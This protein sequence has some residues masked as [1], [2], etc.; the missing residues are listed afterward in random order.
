M[1]PCPPGFRARP[2]PSPSR[3]PGLMSEV[4]LPL[5]AVRQHRPSG[6]PAH[7]TQ[8][9]RSATA[10]EETVLAVGLEARH[11]DARRQL[12]CLEHLAAL[13]IDATQLAFVA[14]P[15][16]M[17]HLAV[18]PGDASDKT[19]RLDGAQDL[20]GFRIDLVNL[21]F[22]VHAYPQRAFGPGHAG[23][24]AITRRRNRREHL[25]GLRVYL[26]DARFGDL[27]QVLAIP[28]SA[29]VG[30]DVDGAP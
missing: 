4:P 25:A 21:A 8:F 20:S 15:G 23:V 29:R 1:S 16:G 24:S 13:R 19:I 9:S 10:A 5:L 30:G 26:L 27:V 3:N 12:K 17:P 18:D 6:G 7:R 2:C 14:L 28:G 22:A 11:R